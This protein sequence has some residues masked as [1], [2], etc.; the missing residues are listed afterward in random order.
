MIVVIICLRLCLVSSE[1][2]E[3][4]SDSEPKFF[5]VEGT[6]TSRGLGSIE[7]APPNP[8]KGM[9]GGDREVELEIMEISYY[10]M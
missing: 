3:S 6:G 8:S 5:L 9:T 2:W 4:L 7:Q 10:L 1:V